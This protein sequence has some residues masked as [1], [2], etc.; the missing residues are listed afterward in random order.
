MKDSLKRIL[1]N[2]FVGA[3][4][5]VA[6]ITYVGWGDVFS[7]IAGA[8]S[9]LL[10][11]GLLAGIT[12]TI[13]RGF[14]W[15]VVFDKFDYSYNVFELFKYYYAGAFANGITPLGIA[16]GEPLIAYIISKEHDV[17]YEKKLG[18]IF[19]SDIMIS[20]PFLTMSLVGL[21]YFLFLY[22]SRPIISILSAFILIPSIVIILFFIVTWHLKDAVKKGAVYLRKVVLFFIRFITLKWDNLKISGSGNM[23][24]KVDRFYE[25]IEFAFS[26]K[27]TVTEAV[28][29][30]HVSRFFDV[31]SLYAF[32]AALGF[33]PS[34]FTVL[35]ILPMAGLGFFLPLPGGLGSQ[36]LILSLLLVFIAN[37][38][39][40]VSSAAVLLY[41]LSTYGFVMLVGGSFAFKMSRKV[42]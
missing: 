34:F 5:L 26:N 13:T 36:Q 33:Q 32:I 28:F 8:D 10:S 19:S 25:T 21:G 17:D 35:F 1:F 9:T 29:I 2:L 14:I 39:I 38:P 27:R 22:H 11:L 18:S 42:F 12:A 30:S 40:S 23:H 3:G 4:I 20:I 31:L 41:R 6:F 15:K 24:E 37:I 16:G 7:A